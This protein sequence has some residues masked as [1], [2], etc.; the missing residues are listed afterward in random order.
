LA[1]GAV[2][3][4][5]G[6]S[7]K[8]VGLIEEFD[9]GGTAHSLVPGPRGDIWFTFETEFHQGAIGRIS[10]QGKVT[11]FRVTEPNAGLNPGGVP[12]AMVAG[13]EGSLWFTGLGNPPAIGRITPEG[14]ITDFSAG[15]N[16]GSSPGDV[17][18]GPDGNI[19]FT[20]NGATKA[21][22]RI[23]PAGTIT[24]FSAGLNP[25]G[26]PDGLLAQPEGNIWFTDKA[27]SATAIG[28][29]TPAGS[30]AE[31]G[32]VP[33]S[34][35]AFD[36][37]IAG[38]DGNLWLASNGPALGI[39]RVTPLG[40]ISEF[41]AG[42]SPQNLELGPLVSGPDGNVWFAARGNRSASP[43]SGSTAAIGRVTPSGTVTEFGKC[44]HP[45]PPFT[46]RPPYTGPISLAV[47]PDGN[48][49]Y[50]SLPAG[51]ASSV[52]STAAIGRVTPSGKVTE[53]RAGLAP[54]SRPVS[55]VAGADGSMWF[56]DYGTF[57]IGRITPPSAPANTF[58]VLPALPAS[59]S[60][61]TSL[62]VVVP[63]PGT[64]KLK[65]IAMLSGRNG[66]IHLPAQR[67]VAAHA[68]SCGRTILHLTPAGIARAQ[69]ARVGAV[70]LK[71]R[72]TFTPTGG[73][74]YHRLAA[75][76]VKRHAPN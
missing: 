15:L 36:E 76:T 43:A 58:L 20:D 47:G 35:Y 9:I 28:R 21:I 30:I 48:I 66:Q 40:E 72:I 13:P 4:C 69:L 1:I 70:R 54:G 53:F 34:V 6:A 59:K 61:R 24:E 17:A 64:L 22:G 67:T 23:T 26:T 2:L 63:G 73:S 39:A 29:I 38:P 45:G 27:G 41:G 8:P 33:S 10:P 14:A 46:G 56:G 18:A 74:S 57:S 62:P 60:G 49:W 68:A 50:T 11:E 3:G 71:A 55:I 16:P 51:H 19:W 44:V 7:A 12:W 5:A 52:G 31:F 75:V 42:I 65:P 32:S 25:Q 37:L